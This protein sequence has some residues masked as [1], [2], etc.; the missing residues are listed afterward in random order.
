MRA[1]LPGDAVVLHR[2]KIERQVLS[3]IDGATVFTDSSHL[4]DSATGTDGHVSSL[5]RQTVRF[6]LDIRSLTKNEGQL[7]FLLQV[8]SEN[9]ERYPQ[10]LK[11]AQSKK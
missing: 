11:R 8:V 9:R 7:Q 5:V 1:V 2:Q 3:E 10:P 4:L 6:L